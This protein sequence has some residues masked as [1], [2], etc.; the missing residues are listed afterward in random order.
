MV[1]G[2]IKATVYVQIHKNQFDMKYIEE[3]KDTSLTAFPP[4]ST[5]RML[6]GEYGVAEHLF[7]KGVKELIGSVWIPPLFR[8]IIH[9]IEM[10]E[11]GL[12]QVEDR[13]FQQLAS[14]MQPRTIKI[15]VGGELSDDEVLTLADIT[16]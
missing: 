14:S 4:F 2:L 11:G 5:Q 8:I 13:V 3:Q 10:T 7:K 16:S 12:C 9:P 6:V 15:H 1:T